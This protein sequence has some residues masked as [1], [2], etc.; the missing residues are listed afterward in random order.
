M[1]QIALLLSLIFATS[2]IA[3]L[4][5][6]TL[7]GQEDT[8]KITTFNFKTP[9][10]QATKVDG[11]TLIE[12]GNLNLLENPGFEHSTAN[13][14]WTAA[15][16]GGASFVPQ[17]STTTPF[18]GKKSAFLT[19][20]G[21]FAAGT[22]TFKQSVP[23]THAVQGM[24]S[25]WLKSDT[26]TVVKVFSG[27]N[28]VRG[29]SE[30]VARENVGLFKH[31]EIP[32]TLGT[33][34]TEVE[35]EIT[36]AN[37][38]TIVVY[39]DDAFVGRKELKAD[40]QQAQLLGGVLFTT[41]GTNTTGWRTYTGT[42][43][44]YTGTA[45]VTFN[46]T[47]KEINLEKAGDYQIHSQITYAASTAGAGIASGL[48]VNG[49]LEQ[50]VNV[51]LGGGDT[52]PRGKN[53]CNLKNLPANSKIILRQYTSAS[54]GGDAAQVDVIYYPPSSSIISH[55]NKNF[56][57]IDGGPITLAGELTAPTKGTIVVDKVWYRRV[58]DSMEIRYSYAQ[59]TGGAAGSGNYLFG[60][61]GGYQ[62][63]VTKLAGVNSY[64]SN[65]GNFGGRNSD[66]SSF[67][68]NLTGHFWVRN[69]NYLG[70]YMQYAQDT[71]APSTGAGPLGS[72]LGSLANL[73][74]TY[75][76]SV[77]VPIKG[78]D[79]SELA[80][81]DIS[82]LEQCKDS[83]ECT[84]HYTVLGDSAGVTSRENLEWVTGNCSIP[85]TGTYNC[86]YDGTKSKIGV[87]STFTVSASDA[88]TADRNCILTGLTTTTFQVSCRIAST[89]AAVAVAWYLTAYRT[90]P[91][92][93][94]KRAKAVASDQHITIP[95]LLDVIT[96]YSVFAGNSA[97]SASCTAS[98]CLKVV[99]YGMSGS[100]TVRGGLGWGTHNIPSGTFKPTTWLS[101]GCT[102]KTVG[103]GGNSGGCNV[104]D[105]FSDSSG[106][107]TLVW[108]VHDENSVSPAD[109][110]Q[111]FTCT[112][113][114][115]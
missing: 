21:I 13:S 75:S 33:T 22:C 23:T 92:Y 7:S 2:A 40:I 63:D 57:W 65:V 95:G 91:D 16:T 77:K 11:A 104:L 1:K 6:T 19:C 5:P 49:A 93:L 34:S 17:V 47:T 9:N 59:N 52:G 80:V 76:G 61:P 73:Q 109:G 46:N 105:T 108:T 74:V 27:V 43:A 58:G 20:Q 64:S 31:Y 56:G 82:G 29:N 66:G 72:V 69:E 30:F 106:G 79:N 99:E 112:G 51:T 15:G 28:G 107:A 42:G 70:V 14:G 3:G 67:G 26:H 101:C 90:G 96:V 60:I 71:G 86:T 111:T 54:L 87:N 45:G 8:S 84:D 78:W 12:T 98:P 25:I 39:A 89:N 37:G 88:S 110:I 36:V 97:G 68:H 94:G 35:I 41:G 83:Y 48:V 53:V 55:K 44:T 113:P 18:A 38:Q 50:C 62:I 102:T 10:K 81:I 85:S 114:Q 115:S 24:A 4:P 100:S 103:S 32:V